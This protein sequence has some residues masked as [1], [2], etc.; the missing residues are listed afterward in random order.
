[1]K[2]ML[3]SALTIEEKE[4]LLKD[5]KILFKKLYDTIINIAP[6]TT[7]NIRTIDDILKEIELENKKIE[8]FK[9]EQQLKLEN[10]KKEYIFK[11]KA[12]SE[13][14]DAFNS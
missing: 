4:I 1:M 6:L 3:Q 11:L 10:Y 7:P 9:K 2:S 8:D 12:K 5:T 13:L 14:L